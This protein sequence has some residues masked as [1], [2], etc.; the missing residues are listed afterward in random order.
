M[1]EVEERL[2]LAV[3]HLLLEIGADRV[4]SEVPDDC[5][6]AEADRIAGVLQAPAK[7]DVVAGGGIEDVEAADLL[8]HGLLEGH[9]AAGNVLSHHVRK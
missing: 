3:A 9:V 8:Q 2:R 4:S 1:L 5:D 7:I 6:R